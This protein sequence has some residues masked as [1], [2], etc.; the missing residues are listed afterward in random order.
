MRMSDAPGFG[1]TIGIGTTT[2][3]GGT[4]GRILYDN[5]GVIGEM[6]TTGSGTVVVLAT[7]AT[8]VTPTLGVAIG[9]SLALGG[10][11]IGA[12]ALAITGTANVSGVV[13]A[14]SYTSGNPNGGTAASWK[15]GVRVS[16]ASVLDATQ[17]LQV[18]VAGTL[19]KVCIAV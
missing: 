10:A 11:T 14:L 6:T 16:G 7:G 19:Y 13:T 4:S 17:Y 15:F 12:N 1:G 5:G 8:L 2:I 18:D 3:S 9:T